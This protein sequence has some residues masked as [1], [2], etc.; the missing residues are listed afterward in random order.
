MSH[1]H[2]TTCPKLPDTLRISVPKLRI[3][4]HL[5]GLVPVRDDDG[6]ER[7]ELGVQLLVVDRPEAVEGQRLLV[8]VG[9]V[10]HLQIGLVAHHMVDEAEA[11][12]R[13]AG[14]QFVLGSDRLLVAGQEQAAVRAALHQRVGRVTVLPDTQ[15]TSGRRTYIHTC[16][17]HSVINCA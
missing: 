1:W 7:R 16:G 12:R 2:I 14:Q 13:Q 5:D 8:P 3:S 9:H 17:N 4:A 10:V 11:D 6:P 15:G